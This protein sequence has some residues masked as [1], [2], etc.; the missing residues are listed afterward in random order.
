MS[1][2]ELE[3]REPRAGRIYGVLIH[4]M[5]LTVVSELTDYQHRGGA[6]R[7]VLKASVVSSHLTLACQA[8]MSSPPTLC[9]VPP[10]S[11]SRSLWRSCRCSASQATCDPPQSGR[12]KSER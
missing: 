9:T 7:A 11:T 5:Q 1:T 12:P 8:L 3:H 4:G 2:L 10:S 6:A